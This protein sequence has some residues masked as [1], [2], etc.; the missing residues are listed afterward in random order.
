M[1]NIYPYSSPI[2]LTQDIFAKYGGDIG[3]IEADEAYTA[4]YLL[5]EMAVWSEL[6]TFLLPTL[7]TGTQ[8]FNPSQVFM[9]DYTYVNSV[10]KI[11]FIDTKED[12]YYTISGTDN[13]HASLRDPLRG[14]V[15]IHTIIGSCNCSSHGRPYPYQIQTVYTAGLPTGTASQP[16][17]LMA[18][19]TYADIILNEMVGFGN[20]GAGDIGVAS[21][22]NQDY[23]ENRVALLRTTF[24]TSARAQFVQKLLAKYKVRRKVKLL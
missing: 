14:I 3:K 5:S 15:D 11:R 20:E 16:D 13:I 18:L 19:V 2:I 12:T 23:S 6:S 24:G 22:K 1:N 8:H 4:A 17:I 10:A 21:F 7:V 9:L